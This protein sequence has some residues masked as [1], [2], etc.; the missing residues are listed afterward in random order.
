MNPI[1]NRPQLL[2]VINLIAL[3]V[4]I[5]LL[6][7]VYITIGVSA[8]W[9][10]ILVISLSV[11]SSLL[12]L[13]KR[14]D[15]QLIQVIRA[16]ANGDNSLGFSANHPM[17]QSFEGVKQQMQSARFVAEQK[18]EFLKALLIHVE[19]AVIVCD[20]QG[21]IIESNP[22]VARLLGK[23]AVHLNELSH[24]GTLI[25]AAQKNVHSTVQWLHGEQ[26]DTLTLQVSI[27]E[28]QGQT[29]K[30]VTLQSIHELLLN[31]E[32]Q[33][34]KRLTHV[35]THEVANTITPLAS[36]AQTCQGLIP[37]SLSF[38]DEENKQDLTLALKT[39]AARTQYLGEFIASFR[40]ISSLP[41]P[42][43][44]PTQLATILA[45]IEML[46]RQQLA[47]CNTTLT[48][49]IQNKQLVMLDSAQIE[50]VLIN[51]IKNAIEA[52]KSHNNQQHNFK[53]GLQGSS[54]VKSQISLTVAQNKAQQ[55]Y[56]E[57]AD[58]GTGIRENVIE[59]IFV[60]FFTTKQQGSGI[61]LSLSRQIM[62]N[63]GGDLVYLTRPKGACFRCL[64]G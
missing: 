8:T 43:L 7:S 49:D 45:R 38:I 33:A 48:I 56:V 40:Q 13:F 30:I 1:K 16:L 21:N 39:L 63:H 34:Y 22:A 61:G 27:A 3:F 19:L 42:N 18:S 41:M 60:P 6:T 9:L 64:F 25:L 31:K 54:A 36:I 50:Q 59:M 55:L 4:C 10:L 17:R 37:K 35:L 28:I 24:I 12:T 32:Q 23:S 20:A 51:L 53:D 26:Q 11:I 58:N 29:R 44:V 5:T 2:L 14:Q 62:I 46:H 52:I 57:V 47:E 15:Q